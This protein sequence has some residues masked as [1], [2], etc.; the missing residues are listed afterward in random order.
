[1]DPKNKNHYFDSPQNYGRSKLY[2]ENPHLLAQALKQI[3][4]YHYVEIIHSLNA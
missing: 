4:Y 2:P 1:M 3:V